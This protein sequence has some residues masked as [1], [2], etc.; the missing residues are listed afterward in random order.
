MY[1]YRIYKLNMVYSLHLQ[2]AQVGKGRGSRVERGVT[3]LA[4]NLHR[5]KRQSNSNAAPGPAAVVAAVVSAV[6]AV[7]GVARVAAAAALLLLTAVAFGIL[8]P[9]V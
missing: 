6:A 9:I 5:D 1:I 4:A 8:G 2:A 3:Q 7:S